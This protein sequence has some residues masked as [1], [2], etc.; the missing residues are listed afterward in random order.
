MNLVNHESGDSNGAQGDGNG[1]GNGFDDHSDWGD[2]DG[3]DEKRKIAEER[4]KE[5]R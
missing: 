1:N 4:L 2:S 3:T 5:S